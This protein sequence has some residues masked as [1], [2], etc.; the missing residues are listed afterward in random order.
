MKKLFI[1]AIVMVVAAITSQAAY[2]AGGQENK[3]PKTIIVTGF[4]LSGKTPTKGILIHPNWDNWTEVAAAGVESGFNYIDNTIT[5]WFWVSD[6]VRWTGTG[7]YSLLVDVRPGREAGKSGSVYF[8]NRSVDIKEA[9]TTVKWSD[10]EYGWEF[11]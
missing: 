6:G 4:N 3:E 7:E 5:L 11:D 10:F 8:L 9:E 1:I 2:A